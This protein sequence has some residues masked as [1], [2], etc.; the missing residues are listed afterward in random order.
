MYLI[1]G[2][3]H[4]H[5]IMSKLKRKEQSE[6]SGSLDSRAPLDANCVSSPELSP[7]RLVVFARVSP[8]S[9]LIP[10]QVPAG[11]ASRHCAS[12]PMVKGDLSPPRSALPSRL[13]TCIGDMG[14]LHWGWVH[15]ARSLADRPR[16]SV[17]TWEAFLVLKCTILSIP[18][19]EINKCTWL[20]CFFEKITIILKACWNFLD[21]SLSS[22]TNHT[23]RPIIMQMK[24]LEL[25]LKTT[26]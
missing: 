21:A 7:C 18:W 12:S 20:F 10:G 26:S 8:L 11:F 19:G 15:P 24:Q 4:V 2:T 25:F 23:L 1:F 22:Y 17:L 16:D 6:V 9:N 3:S 14:R 13:P 5:E